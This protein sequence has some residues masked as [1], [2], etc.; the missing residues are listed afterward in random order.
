MVTI[1]TDLDNPYSKQLSRFFTMEFPQMNGNDKELT[2][3]YVTKALIATNQI[4]YGPV[5]SPESLVAI[6]STVRNSIGRNEP[7]PILMPF[8]SRKA[9]LGQQ[10]D[11]AEVSALK[12]IACLQGRVQGRYSPG[13]QLN[14][15]IEDVSGNSLFEED[16]DQS[17]KESL[18]YCLNFVNLIR[19]LGYDFIHPVLESDMFT[20]EIFNETSAKILD[21]MIEYL[22][23]TDAY[24]IQEHEK[25]SS[26]KKLEEMGYKGGISQDQRDY[27]RGRYKAWNPAITQYEASVKLA[28]YQ[29]GVWARKL[30][31]GSGTNPI[32][33]KDYLRLTFSPP[34]PGTPIGV[35]DKDIYYRTLPTK[36]AMTHIPPWRAKGFLEISNEEI[37]PKLAN[38]GDKKNYSPC[39]VTFIEGTNQVDVRADYIEVEE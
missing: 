31:G 30:L 12:T 8:G 9:I 39:K 3:E 28:K 21:V 34:V 1:R 37:T 36:F 6:R 35:Y 17:R 23:E 14:I 29:A 27:Y 26:Y 15:R 22:R 10:L 5:P 25:L 11:I 18:D 13:I 16:G 24:G 4:R 20:E 33:G 7:I 19:V 38:F 2:L 32:W